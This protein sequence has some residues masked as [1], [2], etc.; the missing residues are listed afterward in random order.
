[1]KNIQYMVKEAFRI[2]ELLKGYE[3]CRLERSTILCVKVEYDKYDGECIEKEIEEDYVCQKENPFYF[4]PYDLEEKRKIAIFSVAIS[5]FGVSWN[6]ENE[7][8]VK[9]ETSG[10]SYKELLENN[11]YIAMMTEALRIKD[12]L[13]GSKDDR[14]RRKITKVKLTKK[15]VEPVNEYKWDDSDNSRS[16]WDFLERSRYYD[17]DSFP[18]PPSYNLQERED[19]ANMVVALCDCDCECDSKIT[20]KT[21]NDVVTI[22]L[23]SDEHEG[24][25]Y[26]SYY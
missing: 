1:M 14:E 25:G 8:S 21:C 9:I 6:P 17:S 26:G 20:Y 7:E 15:R 11:S 19:I 23:G 10:R 3:R 2:I 5:D 16:Y 13:I 24:Y 12:E 18:P 4:E 22:S